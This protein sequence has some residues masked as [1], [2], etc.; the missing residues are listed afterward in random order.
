MLKFQIIIVESA[1]CRI[2]QSNRAEAMVKR[3]DVDKGFLDI[4][5]S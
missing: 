3:I 5:L 2:Q 4:Y 1:L